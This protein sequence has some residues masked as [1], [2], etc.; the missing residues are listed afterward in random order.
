[1]NDPD[2]RI[3]D[4]AYR[5]MRHIEAD[6]E[7][8]VMPIYWFGLIGCVFFGILLIAGVLHFQH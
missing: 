3:E 4:A 2:K 6:R 1:M 8:R 7:A 5:A